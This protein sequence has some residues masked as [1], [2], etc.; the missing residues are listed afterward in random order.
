MYHLDVQNATILIRFTDTAK[1][2]WVFKSISAVNAYISLRLLGPNLTLSTLTAL[3]VER[4][5]SFLCT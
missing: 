1:I 4:Q 3:F 2:I 5:A